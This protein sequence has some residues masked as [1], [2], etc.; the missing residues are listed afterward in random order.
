LKLYRNNAG[1]FVDATSEAGLVVATGAVRQP[2]FVDFDGD[3]DL[4]LFIAFR[5]R[6]NALYR[7]DAGNF[8]DVAGSIGL[9]DKRRTVGAVWF[10]FDEDGDLD[11]AV[12]NMDGDANGLYRNDGGT[13]TDAAAAAGVEWGGRAPKSAGNGTVRM[14]AADV[15]GDGRFDLFAANYGPL[16]FFSNRGKGVFE[17]RSE[18]WAIAIDSRYDSCAFADFDH[19]GRLDLYVNG[20]ITGGA[21]WQDSLFRNTGSAFVDVTPP[22]IR[23]L[24]ADHG[25]Q[26]VDVDGDTDLDLA[27]TGSRADGTHVVM[28]N[29]LPPGDAARGVQVRVVDDQNRAVRAGTEVRVFAPGSSRLLGARLVDSGSGYNSQNDLPV[30]FGLPTTMARVDLQIIIPRGGKRTPIWLRGTKV[31]KPWITVRTN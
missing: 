11:V 25:V 30:H 13:F 8:T 18:A 15:D 24:Q 22:S 3:N 2:V 26:W 9:A 21:S 6:G 28:R 12:A 23:A 1:K 29:L 5:D 14:C 17:D 19:D 10:D 27:L 20:T 4:D 16:G 7:N 31:D